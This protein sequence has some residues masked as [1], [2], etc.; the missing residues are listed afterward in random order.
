MESKSTFFILIIIVAVLALTL[1]ALAGYLFIV[2]GASDKGTV[3]DSEIAEENSVGEE[4]KDIPKK[5]DRITISLYEGKRIYNLKNIDSDKTA[6]MQVAVS[7]DCFKTL[8]EDR[9][10][11]VGDLITSYSQEIQELV[12][13][14]FL[15]KTIDDVKDV[16]VMDKAKEELTEQINGLLNESK[17][18]PEYIVYKVIFS[19]WIFQ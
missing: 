8:K 11:V 9:K 12:V 4:I 16:A 5:E 19:E 15:T 1:A 3:S 14:F 18:K 10:T 17:K 13:R 7:L 6:M 2:Q